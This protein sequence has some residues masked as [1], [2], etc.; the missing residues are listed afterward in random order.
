MQ[1]I[2]FDKNSNLLKGAALLLGD[3]D[4]VHLGH[5]ELVKAALSYKDIPHAALLFDQDPSFFLDNGKSKRILTTLEDKIALFE[6]LGLDT[7]YIIHVDSSFFSLTPEEFIDAYLR[8]IEPYVLISGSDYRFGKKAAGDVTLLAKSFRL[9]T[10]DLLY[11]EEKKIASR[12]IKKMISDGLVEVAQEELGRPYCLKGVVHEGFHNG[13]T[14]GF[15]TLN[16]HL[17][18]PYILPKGGVYLTETEINGKRYKSITNIGTNPTVGLLHHERV[19]SYLKGFEG[20]A[21]E[22]RISV[23]FLKRIRDE[24]KFSSLDELRAQLEKDKALLD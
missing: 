17:E 8:P 14:I 18:E 3:F 19:E 10:V 24:K 21:Y 12:D 4:G 16:L 5:Q 11:R 6:S 22:E 15:P 1:L 7:A 9:K 20:N 13:R 2:H 23:Y